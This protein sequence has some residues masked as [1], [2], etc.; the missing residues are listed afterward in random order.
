MHTED[1]SQPARR[2]PLAD[3]RI[4]AIEQYGA[5]PF[6]SLHLADLGA[7]VIKIE[8]PNN[9]GDIG[10][11]IPPF[12]THEDSL[13]FQT[14]NRN[15]LSINLD[16]ASAAGRRVL[17]DLVSQSDAVY[18]NLRG[19]VPARLRIRYD[20]LKVV[21]PRIV[22]CSLTGFGMTGPRSDQAGYDYLIQG[23]TGWMELTGEPDGPPEK[24]GASLV[25]YSGGYVA[26]LS[27]LAA[28]HAARTTGRG[29]DCDVS[30][31]DTAASLLTYLGTWH[32]TSGYQPVR[33]RHSAHPSVVPFQNFQ[34]A[35]GW[36][37]VAC[38]KEKFWQR[39]AGG[40]GLPELADE[41]FADMTSRAEHRHELLEMLERR[42]LEESTEHWLGLLHSIGVP[43]GPVNTVEQAL[44]DPHLSARGMIIET[45]HPAFGTV[46]Q[47]A[48]PVRVGADRPV[49]R[50]A[51]RR[52]EDAA[53]VLREVAGYDD[54]LIAELG[55][56]GAF[57]PIGSVPDQV[58][59]DSQEVL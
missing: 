27:L 37:V 52:N 47:L 34:T 39:L 53:Y 22:C 54:Q 2:G 12:Q 55:R 33:S 36:V 32:L 9:G 30:L 11:Y 44:S 57:G 5:G 28:V 35:D 56:A 42:F 31:Y 8:D 29:A 58:L 48:S 40:I 7:E 51:P 43:S 19:D 4:L 18:S 15:K 49:H 24:S 38:A 25:D 46:R 3:L 41:R 50:R 45:E 26:A 14:F 17:E 23:L 21:N 10:R 6:G 16:V 20:D 59:T 1:G 13:F